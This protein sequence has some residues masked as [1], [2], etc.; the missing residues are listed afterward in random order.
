MGMNDYLKHYKGKTVLIT[1]GAGAISGHSIIA[2]K[3]QDADECG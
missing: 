1:G 2:G 3:I